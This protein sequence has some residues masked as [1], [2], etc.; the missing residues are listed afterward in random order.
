MNMKK[1][2]ILVFSLL[3]VAGAN[4]QISKSKMLSSGVDSIIVTNTGT[5]SLTYGPATKRPLTIQMNIAKASGTLGGTVTLYGSADGVNYV[6]LTD[7]TSTP[8]ITT[9]TVTDTGTYTARQMKSWYLNDHE[10]LYYKVTWVGT[11]TMAGSA[12]AFIIGI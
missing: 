6:A 7:A 8:T 11:G 12:K 9:Y 5:S 4:A 2:L 3:V 10:Y 1:F